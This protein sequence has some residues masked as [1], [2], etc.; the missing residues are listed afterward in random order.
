MKQPHFPIVNAMFQGEQGSNI[1]IQDGTFIQHIQPH[2][3]A[4]KIHTCSSEK[5]KTWKIAE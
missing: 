1:N 2:P 3:E 4:S 5:G